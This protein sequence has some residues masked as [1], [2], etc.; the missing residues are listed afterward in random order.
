MCVRVC[1]VD[2]INRTAVR[3]TSFGDRLQSEVGMGLTN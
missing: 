2:E 3:V 1:R